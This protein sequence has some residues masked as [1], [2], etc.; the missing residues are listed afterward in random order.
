VFSLKLNLISAKLSIGIL[1][2]PSCRTRTPKHS[3]PPEGRAWSG[4]H[5]SCSGPELPGTVREPPRRV[6]PAGTPRS[7][8]RGGGGRRPTSHRRPPAGAASPSPV[9][10]RPRH[11][12]GPHLL[13]ASAKQNRHA[14]CC[15][16]LRPDAEA[17][18]PEP[19]FFFSPD[20]SEPRRAVACRAGVPSYPGRATQPSR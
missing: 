11:R 10:P 20:R 15:R 19:R 17:A 18:E 16:L 5:G 1:A 9:A 3:A 13:R 14:S 7:R 6:T 2:V 8:A 12:R 4:P